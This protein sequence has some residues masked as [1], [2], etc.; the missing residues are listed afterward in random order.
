MTAASCRRPCAAS[1]LLLLLLIVKS[2][3]L[4]RSQGRREC[5]GE[6]GLALRDKQVHLAKEKGRQARGSLPSIKL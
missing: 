6:A 1:E 2:R 5:E 3:A 4:R